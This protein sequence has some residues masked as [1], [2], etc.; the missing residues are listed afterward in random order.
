[1]RSWRENPDGEENQ[2]AT[3]QSER[4]VFALRMMAKARNTCRKCGCEIDDTDEC[5]PGCLDE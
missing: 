5:C 2:R 3:K 4:E 1:M